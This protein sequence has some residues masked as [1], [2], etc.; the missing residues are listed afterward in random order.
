RLRSRPYPR[1]RAA[2]AAVPLLRRA[3]EARAMQIRAA[4][5]SEFAAIR[6][7]LELAGLPTGDLSTSNIE[8][9]IAVSEGKLEGVLGLESFGSAALLRSLAVQPSA[10]GSGIASALVGELELRSR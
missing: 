5:A 7:L 10:R 6:D 1:P 8:W 2:A 3:A 4:H 9:L